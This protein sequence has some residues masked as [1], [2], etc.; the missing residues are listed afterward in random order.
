MT[1]TPLTP[2]RKAPGFLLAVLMAAM[3]AGPVFNYGVGALS[4]TIVDSYGITEGQY[5]CIITAVFL[6]AGVTAPVLG[7]LADRIDARV[8]LVLIFGGV[9]GAFLLSAAR[10]SYAVLLVS[11][12]IAGVAQSFSNPVTNRIVARNVPLSQRATWMGWKQSGV[13]VGLLVSG[14]TFPVIGA[15]AGWRGA[16]LFGAALCVPALLA[17][18]F[19]VTRL[20]RRAAAHP[21]T[22]T[23]PASQPSSPPPARHTTTPP[24]SQRALPGT[25][26]PDA[27]DPGG[28]PGATP[29]SAVRSTAGASAGTDA[30]NGARGATAA[31]AREATS[32][33]SRLAAEARADLGTISGR[34][35]TA[36]GGGVDR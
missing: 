20:Q 26:A 36:P 1:H 31:S 27:S 5:G 24:A 3:A 4:A 16:A 28:A 35:R 10:Q 15:A 33:H 19:V 17:G 21:A 6:L 18:W 11:A 34:A 8:Q 22:T 14:L 12:L 7:V 13:Q 29:A 30:E 32:P 23:P 25:T 9:L 2:P